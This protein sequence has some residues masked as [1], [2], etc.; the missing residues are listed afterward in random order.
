VKLQGKRAYSLLYLLLHN[1]WLWLKYNGIY[2][3]TRHF[4]WKSQKNLGRL[5]SVEGTPL[6]TRHPF[7]RS[8]PPRAW[9]Y[10]RHMASVHV[11]LSEVFMITFCAKFTA[12]NTTCSYSHFYPSTKHAIV[13]ISSVR[14]ISYVKSTSWQQITTDILLYKDRYG[15]CCTI[16]K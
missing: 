9:C 3:K 12:N 6:P 10:Q 8:N 4:K 2:T 16:N 11:W 7:A 15:I 1:A 13:G 5:P 14:I